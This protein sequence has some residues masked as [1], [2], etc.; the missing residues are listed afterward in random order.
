[1]TDKTNIAHFSPLGL[2]L[3]LDKRAMNY[4][5]GLSDFWAFIF[6]DTGKVNL[7]LEGTTFTASEIYSRFLQITTQISL[8]DIQ[9]EV[10][11]QAKLVL[12]GEADIVPGEIETYSPPEKINSTRLICN[13][14]LLPTLYLEENIDYYIDTTTGYIRFARPLVE[15]GFPSRFLSDGTRQFALWFIDC[16]VDENLV[17]DYYAKLLGIADP[18]RA[19]D[20]FKNFIYG[21]Y[22]LYI[23]GP[24]IDQI[25]MGLNLVLGIP[26]ARDNESVLEIRKHLN[27]DNYLVITDLNSYLIPYGLEPTVAVGDDL[28]VGTEISSWVEVKDYYSDGEWWINLMI[29]RSIM[30]FVP[31]G[32]NRYAS[33]GS[34][35]DYLMKEYLHK[36]TFLVN[37]KTIDFKNIQTFSDIAA[38]IKQIKPSHTTPL[39]VWTVPTKDEILDMSESKPEIQIQLNPCEHL[40]S[41]IEFFRRDSLQP[42]SRGCSS[43]TRF[44]APSYIN[45]YVGNDSYANGHLRS[46]FGGL[47]TGMIGQHTK[48]KTL[49]DYELNWI[50]ACFNRNNDNYRP[51]RS[52]I[53]FTRGVTQLTD[54]GGFNYIASLID[55]T[56]YRAV[57]L[58]TTVKPDVV[59]K[60]ATAGKP[61]IDSHWFTLLAPETGEGSINRSPINILPINTGEEIDNYDFLYA[62]F[63]YFFTRDST[64]TL[65]TVC[66]PASREQFTPN[67]SELKN[68]DYLLFV[69]IDEYI[70]GVYWITTNLT[71]KGSPY[72]SIDRTDE[73]VVETN[74]LFNR[75]MARGS[76][77]WFWMRG[78]AEI[79]GD[80]KAINTFAI[81]NDPLGS[82]SVEVKYSDD[83]NDTQTMDRS[84]VILKVRL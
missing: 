56:K 33:T 72:V 18:T 68:G 25:R 81:D 79:I 53:G 3:G 55:R 5:Y 74:G 44:C 17:Y 69:H 67:I 9:S 10:G 6:S 71:Y 14:G 20:N 64:Y 24:D 2:D 60:F 84:G 31:A 8:E 57:Y 70:F 19:S 7:L 78:T 13:R 76:S 51:P 80:T 46:V 30:P 58:Y 59:A 28:K 48:I 26:V 40:T 77:P 32:H 29:P 42:F 47:A 54:G 12:I 21:L 49:S 11:Y 34:Y 36:H 83:L 22:Y 45:K 41:G 1:M 61:L 4:L 23:H 15:Y 39:Y 37:V 43:F 66:P 65:P 82:S 27:S 62:N 75:G 50:T 63:D 16:R 73:P 38:I 35:A 52:Y